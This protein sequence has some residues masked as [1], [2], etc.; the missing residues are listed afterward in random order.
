M[1]LAEPAN[2]VFDFFSGRLHFI[3]VTDNT[4][5]NIKLWH[6]L[7][8]FES[9]V[10]GVLLQYNRIKADLAAIPGALMKRLQP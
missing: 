8:T 10:Y 3:D 1:D 9:H 7:S 6:H 2:I 4:L 5:I